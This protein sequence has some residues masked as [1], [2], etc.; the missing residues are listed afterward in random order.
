MFSTMTILWQS[1]IRLI[2]TFR[3]CHCSEITTL[4][5]GLPHPKK[6]SIAEKF[7]DICKFALTEDSSNN[8]LKKSTP[9]FLPNFSNFAENFFA[10]Y[11]I[12]LLFY[13]LS[14][15]TFQRV[16]CF[17]VIHCNRSNKSFVIWEIT[18]SSRVILISN[19]MGF[20]TV[21]M[22]TARNGQPVQRAVTTYAVIRIYLCI[23]WRAKNFRL[24]RKHEFVVC[25]FSCKILK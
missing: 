21:M 22:H 15:K 10:I 12:V 8:F 23:A 17:I 1:I 24:L 4:I 13:V 16:V 5:N 7:S 20:G 25:E 14:G 18:K 6:R 3:W 11:Q 2:N 9:I 19:V